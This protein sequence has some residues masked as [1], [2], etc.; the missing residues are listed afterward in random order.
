MNDQDAVN[1]KDRQTNEAMGGTFEITDEARL[2]QQSDPNNHNKSGDC[3]GLGF[4]YVTASTT[5][6]SEVVPPTYYLNLC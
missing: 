3:N 1:G 5:Y 6:I 2:K 4:P